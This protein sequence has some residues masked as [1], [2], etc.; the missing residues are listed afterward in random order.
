MQASFFII[1][2]KR[3]IQTLGTRKSTTVFETVP[4]RSLTV[5]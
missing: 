3:G 2:G 4:F 1:C 5:R